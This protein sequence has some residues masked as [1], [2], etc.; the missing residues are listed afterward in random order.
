MHKVIHDTESGLF[1]VDLEQDFKA[2]VVYEL[3][4]DVM[5]ITSTVV[6]E[7]LRG[8]GYGKVMME[9]VLPEI[10]ALGYKIEPVCPY[11]THY[12]NRNQAWSHLLA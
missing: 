7:E 2:K 4:N 5:H 11:V 9:A 10:E 1:W 3:K 8:K 6:P 12:I